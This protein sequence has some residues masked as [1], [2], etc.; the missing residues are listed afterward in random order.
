MLSNTNYDAGFE[1]CTSPN[2]G[3]P[4]V[5]RLKNSQKL[6]LSSYTCNGRHPDIVALR[7]QGSDFGGQE[8][9]EDGLFE[10]YN[11]WSNGHTPG[12]ENGRLDGIPGIYGHQ[13]DYVYIVSYSQQESYDNK[14]RIQEYGEKVQLHRGRKAALT[15]GVRGRVEYVSQYAPFKETNLHHFVRSIGYVVEKAR[16]GYIFWEPG[17]GLGFDKTIY[18]LTFATHKEGPNLKQY[19]D[20]VQIG[21]TLHVVLEY[22]QEN[23]RGISTVTGRRTIIE[24]PTCIEKNKTVCREILEIFSPAHDIYKYAEDYLTNNEYVLRPRYTAAPSYD[25]EEEITAGYTHNVQDAAAQGNYATRAAAAQDN[26]AGEW[27]QPE[28]E[29]EFEAQRAAAARGEDEAEEEKEYINSPTYTPTQ[30][31]DGELSEP[32]DDSEFEVSDYSFHTPDF[33]ILPRPTTPVK[34]GYNNNKRSRK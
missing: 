26:C 30:S 7:E 22:D 12:Q 34:R 1:R 8:L 20:Y 5:Q 3:N 31:E 11:I 14:A 18:E 25:I 2:Q 16:Q 23:G 27:P 4:C 13:P 6:Q 17:Q 21:D 10:V 19:P 32:S 28:P 29:T 33:N 9:P 15:A 24:S